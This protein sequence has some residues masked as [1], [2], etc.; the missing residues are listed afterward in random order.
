MLAQSRAKNF[1]EKRQ[2]RLAPLGSRVAAS[3][4]WSHLPNQAASGVSLLIRKVGLRIF[5]G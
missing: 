4:N 2:R 1:G 5:K 3:K